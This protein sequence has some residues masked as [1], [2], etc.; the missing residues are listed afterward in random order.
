MLRAEEK[1]L[2]L[3]FGRALALALAAPAC[4]TR[5]ETLNPDATT[6]STMGAEAG[7]A[8]SEAEASME[9]AACA[10]QAYTPQVMDLCAEFWIMP[11]GLPNVMPRDNCFLSIEDCNQVCNGFFYNCRTIDDSCDLDSGKTLLD[12]EAG[13]AIE[14]SWCVGGPG[15]APAGLEPVR[16]ARTLGGW[17][18]RAAHLEAASVHAFRTMQRELRSLGAPPS[19]V[20]AA[21][22]AERDEV[23]HARMTARLAREHGERTVKPRASRVGERSLE[24]IALENVVQGCVGETYAALEAR[25]QAERGPI[26]LRNTM[27]AIAKDELRHAALAWAFAKWA[28]P[29]L[30]ASARIRI[31]AARDRALS[32]LEGAPIESNAVRDGAGLPD[33]ATRAVLLSHIRSLF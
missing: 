31:D 30:S 5:G 20:R 18:A 4:S 13:L 10:K 21:R 15:R 7:D 2:A 24:A 19:F 22:R 25:H 12:A 16:F 29:R 32:D 3:A 14:C 33:A 9:D 26:A 23:R 6:D 28:R 11:C 27:R 17:F 8:G 1:R